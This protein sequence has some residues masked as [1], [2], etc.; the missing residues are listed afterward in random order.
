M[1]RRTLVP[2]WKVLEIVLGS[3]SV[4]LTGREIV[5]DGAGKGTSQ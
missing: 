1:T 4:T 3:A 5:H 2:G